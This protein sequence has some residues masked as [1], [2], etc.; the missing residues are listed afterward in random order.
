MPDDLL[1]RIEAC[2][3][4][5]RELIATTWFLRRSIRQTNHDGKNSATSP[6]ANARKSDRSKLGDDHHSRARRHRQNFQCSSGFD[7]PVV[8]AFRRTFQ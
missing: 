7:L 5:I 4:R 2:I 3:T 8:S 6:N 1:A